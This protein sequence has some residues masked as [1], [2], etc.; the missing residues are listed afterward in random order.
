MAV[1]NRTQ[2]RPGYRMSHQDRPVQFERVNH[3]HNVVAEAVS[4]VIRGRKT[5]RAEP[6]PRNAVNMVAGRELRCELVEYVRRVP[7]PG[8]EDHR[9]ASPSPIEHFQPHVIVD[10]YKLDG[11]RGWVLP[12]SGRL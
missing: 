3:R 2:F 5:G 10:P 6:A 1:G 9:P 11:V 8:Q 7:T 4:R 12:R